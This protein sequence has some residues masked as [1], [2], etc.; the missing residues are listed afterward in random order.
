MQSLIRQKDLLHRRLFDRA[1]SIGYFRFV[2]CPRPLALMPNVVVTGASTG[3]GFA[4]CQVLIRRGFR[5]F[6]SVRKPA[7]ADRLREQLGTNYVPVLF[8]VTDP[9]SVNQA[10]AAVRE[11]AGEER[12][13]GLVN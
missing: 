13:F 5:V 3:I 9:S 6:G 1:E 4:A 8:D 11:A 12:L 10:A 2:V 7:D